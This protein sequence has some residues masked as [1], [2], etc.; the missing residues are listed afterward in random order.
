MFGRK[1]DLPTLGV[2]IP[3]GD[4]LQDALANGKSKVQDAKKKAREL[5]Q[6][7]KDKKKSKKKVGGDDGASDGDD[8][9]DA[10]VSSTQE[11]SV[12]KD[13]SG[14]GSVSNAEDTDAPSADESTRSDEEGAAAISPTSS[15]SSSSL[16]TPYFETT[17]VD[18]D[19][20]VGRTGQ[21]DIFISARA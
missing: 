11:P 8:A 16:Q 5:L 21:G 19:L 7:A 15:S 17:Y 20:R 18:D 3:S 12:D 9:G 10:D 1:L 14:V 6:K 13:G 4:N 2:D